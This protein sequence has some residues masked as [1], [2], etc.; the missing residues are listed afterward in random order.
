MPLGAP[1]GAGIA[2]HL[3]VTLMKSRAGDEHAC[4]APSSVH[5]ATA[6]QLESAGG[7]LPVGTPHDFLEGLNVGQKTT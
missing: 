4:C 1:Q 6:A 7:L 5:T 3:T 2:S